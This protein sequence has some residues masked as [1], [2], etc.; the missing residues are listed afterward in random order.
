MDE[1][2][3]VSAWTSND[4]NG[5]KDLGQG[6]GPSLEGAKNVLRIFEAVKGVCYIGDKKTGWHILDLLGVLETKWPQ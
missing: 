1:P 6:W 4:P 3:W 2:P 5:E